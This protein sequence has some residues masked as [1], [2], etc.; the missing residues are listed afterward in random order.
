MKLTKKAKVLIMS[1][2]IIATLGSMVGCS[3]IRMIQLIIK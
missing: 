2:M 3:S 1:T